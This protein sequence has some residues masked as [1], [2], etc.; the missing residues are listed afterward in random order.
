MRIHSLLAI[1]LGLSLLASVTAV[2]AVPAGS[3]GT[4]PFP[5][6]RLG[7]ISKLPPSTYPNIDQLNLGWYGNFFP[8]RTTVPA[9]VEFI[10]TI[11]LNQQHGDP[12]SCQY[13]SYSCYSTPPTYT[14]TVPPSMP[15]LAQLV[16]DNPGSLWAV[17]NEPD[18][19]QWWTDGVKWVG[20]DETT[21]ELY[22]RAY[23]EISR[24]IRDTDPTAR[25]AIGGVI[26][27]T[28]LRMEYLDRIWN[29]Y[30][31]VCNGRSLGDDVDVW[32]IHNYVLREASHLCYPRDEAWGPK[33]RLVST[34]TAR[35]RADYSARGQRASRPGQTA[36]TRLPRVD[37]QSRTA[38]QATD[39]YRSGS[40]LG[41]LLAPSR[42]GPGFH[43]RLPGPCPE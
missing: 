37:G 34:S 3:Q 13:G 31:G 8:D 39:R 35:D 1:A 10:R 41:L 29:A 36:H 30:P 21:P 6:C 4:S 7:V 12:Y 38:Q 14:L 40:H 28:P 16:G 42:R 43:D 23:C 25:V 15:Q 11:R 22:A 18:G 2:C 24:L 5:N 17:G 19:R 32:N 20:Q 9:G 27:A 33:F 26:E